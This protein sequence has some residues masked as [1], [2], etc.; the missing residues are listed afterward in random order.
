[1]NDW[2]YCFPHVWDR[3]R[4]VWEDVYLLPDDPTFTGPGLHLTV[5]AFGNVLDPSHG[6]DRAEFQETALAM[7]AGAPYYIEGDQMWLRQED[8]SRDE[9]VGWTRVWLEYHGFS[10]GMLREAAASEFEGRV[11]HAGLVAELKAM[12]DSDE[13]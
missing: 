3:P 10:V 6:S 2:K 8:F 9:L 1:M 11:A 13:D 5:D 7:L 12:Y 4:Q